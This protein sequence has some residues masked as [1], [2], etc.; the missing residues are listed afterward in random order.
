MLSN[1]CGLAALGAISK[2]LTQPEAL[3]LV[4]SRFSSDT[5]SGLTTLM[6]H[7]YSK[8]RVV[9][10]TSEGSKPTEAALKA[11]MLYWV[12]LSYGVIN[13]FGSFPAKFEAD[14]RALGPAGYSVVFADD[15]ILGEKAVVIAP[16]AIAASVGGTASTPASAAL[17]A[18]NPIMDF[19]Q[20]LG[21][22]LTVNAKQKTAD[23][24]AELEKRIQ[25]R[26]AITQRD[27]A[28]IRQYN[29]FYAQRVRSSGSGGSKL[30]I[31]IGALMVVGVGAAI[32]WSR[33]ARK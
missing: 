24:I 1:F 33:Q 30:P 18:A 32:V 19:V 13:P 28:L 2:V 10:G 12:P 3:S 11:D 17:N 20:K 7:L 5:Q 8:Y 4:Q 6:Q 25:R 14:V 21:S 22:G 31:V 29:D 9:E 23:K 15:P 16:E 26:Q 27:A